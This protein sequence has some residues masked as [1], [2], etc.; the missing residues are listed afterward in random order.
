MDVTKKNF[1]SI[2]PELKKAIDE[3]EFIAIDL[4]FTGLSSGGREVEP[5]PFDTPRQYY[6]KLHQ[7]ALDFLPIQFGLCIFQ[8]DSKGNRYT[9]QGYNFYMYPF[10]KLKGFPDSTF[11]SQSSSLAFLISHGFD[12]NKAFGEG[13]SFLTQPQEDRL[14]LTIEERHER[15]EK[16]NGHENEIVVPDDMKTHVQGNI[17]KIKEF[18]EDTSDTQNDCMTLER[19]NAYMRR[20]LYQEVSKKFGDAVHLESCDDNFAMKVFR[21]GGE[22]FKK[23][24][25]EEKKEKEWN[26]FQEAIGLSHLIKA[27]SNSGKLI[28]GH[29]C[30]LDICHIVN[31]FRY[32]L[33]SSYD[34]FKELVHHIFPR[35]IDTKF[36]STAPPIK[37]LIPPCP[38]GKLWDTLR[39]APFNMP[40]VEGNVEGRKYSNLI[41]KSHEGAY[42]ALITGQCFL[43]MCQFLG[44]S[45]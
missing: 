1:A 8:H 29:N 35:I 11:L 6:E 34:N 44:K 43:G 38:L 41:D 15:M 12:F 14:K 30:L 28:I 40:K 17:N 39:E 22:E 32:P 24:R 2:L 27:I 9:Y 20:L 5:L 3:A 25:N 33:P 18:L 7:K 19:C 16:D 4:E 21:G 26:D 37:D 23:K 36:M 13:I 45:I 31:R 10:S 42:D